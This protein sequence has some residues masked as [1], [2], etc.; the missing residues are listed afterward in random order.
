[1]LY[2]HA[3]EHMKGKG[4]AYM[5]RKVREVLT[6]SPHVFVEVKP[7][8]WD[9]TSNYPPEWVED[10]RRLRRERLSRGKRKS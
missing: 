8:V 6:E 4:K 1:M 7:G 10:F 3:G 9:F 5:Q 2:A